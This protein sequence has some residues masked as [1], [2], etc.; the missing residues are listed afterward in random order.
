MAF[1]NGQGKTFCFSIPALDAI[2]KNIPSEV[3]E[4]SKL[5]GSTSNWYPQVIIMEP[6]KD[7]CD[8]TAQRMQAI[9]PPSKDF[10]KI[11]KAY[12]GTDTKGFMGNI[13]VGLPQY[14]TNQKAIK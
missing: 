8:Q 2:D 4:A 14:T 7:L 9:T 1:P 6:T 10:I 11:S 5:R 13:I 3:K 12:G